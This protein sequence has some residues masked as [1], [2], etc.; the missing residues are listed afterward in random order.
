M[1]GAVS[2]QDRQAEDRQTYHTGTLQG[3]TKGHKQE[4]DN[5]KKTR[6]KEKKQY[7]K[8]ENSSCKET[9]SINNTTT[10]HNINTATTHH[11]KLR[12]V[13]VYSTENIEQEKKYKIVQ[14]LW[15]NLLNIGLLH[16]KGIKVTVK[17]KKTDFYNQEEK[18]GKAIPLQNEKSHHGLGHNKGN[19][20]K[21]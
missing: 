8:V 5:R 12:E 21:F 15:N 4:Q 7:K 3:P 11:R 10:Q 18:K 14:D 9:R 17:R 16:E 6:I 2:S 20:N 13:R 1:N 19:R